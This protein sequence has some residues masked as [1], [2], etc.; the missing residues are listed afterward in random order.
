MWEDPRAFF[1]VLSTDFTTHRSRKNRSE[2]KRVII[3][4]KSKSYSPNWPSNQFNFGYHL[5]WD[6][7]Q[8]DRSCFLCFDKLSLELDL[9]PLLPSILFIFNWIGYITFTHNNHA[10]VQAE[11]VYYYLLQLMFWHASPTNNEINQCLPTTTWI[12]SLNKWWYYY[13]QLMCHKTKKRE[14]CDE[15]VE[16]SSSEH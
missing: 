11:S 7:F 13:H 8:R 16:H 12:C 6:I 5:T 1:R 15:Q 9:F 10:F 4:C 14:C 2:S 3:S